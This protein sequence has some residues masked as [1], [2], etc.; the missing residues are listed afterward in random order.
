MTTGVGVV[1]RQVDSGLDGTLSHK[2]LPSSAEI[3]DDYSATRTKNSNDG[4][5]EIVENSET[6]DNSDTNSEENRENRETNDPIYDVGKITTDNEA[7]SAATFQRPYFKSPLELDMEKKLQLL[8][9]NGTLLKNIRRNEA[10]NLSLARANLDAEF[11]TTRDIW[12]RLYFD[13]KSKTIPLDERV[14]AKKSELDRYRD[15]I[16]RLMKSK[17]VERNRLKQS[18]DALWRKR[19]LL[20]RRE[21]RVS[22]HGRTQKVSPLDSNPF[23][24][25]DEFS[26]KMEAIKVE[27]LAQKTENLRVRVETGRE[28]FRRRKEENRETKR[29]IEAMRRQLK[30]IKFKA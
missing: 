18:S 28:E 21:S 14:R 13:A 20:Q 8:R 22:K 27:K 3:R 11:Q 6:V 4:E 19:N 26:L 25:N 9:S 2:S 7:S 1:E 24:L 29:E 10:K 30:E 23:L 12:K 15:E 16:L 5:I 17:V